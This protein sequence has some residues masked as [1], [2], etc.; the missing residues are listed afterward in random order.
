MKKNSC[1]GPF[2]AYLR[3]SLRDAQHPHQTKRFLLDGT[4]GT[5]MR[6]F[7][8]QGVFF[9]GNEHCRDEESLIIDVRRE[10]QA[11]RHSCVEHAKG[12]LVEEEP[13]TRNL[14]RSTQKGSTQN[15]ADTLLQQSC[16]CI[17]WRQAFS[18]YGRELRFNR[19]PPRKR[20]TG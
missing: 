18:D 12:N 9:M 6:S 13:K 15:V 16:H 2:V 7:L 11:L 1:S 19:S 3:P 20:R 10:C 17:S 5:K 4:H 14:S 8:V